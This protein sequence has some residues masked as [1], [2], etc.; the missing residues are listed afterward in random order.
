MYCEL[1]GKAG[2]YCANTVNPNASIEEFI[3]CGVNGEYAFELA[4]AEGT[5][6]NLEGFKDENPCTARTKGTN[7]VCGNAV[8]EDGEECETGFGC[9]T[10]RCKCKNGFYPSTSSDGTCISKNELITSLLFKIV[11]HSELLCRM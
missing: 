3:Y 5:Y 1:Y 4:C 11:E 7:P 8:V 2:Y 10:K 6:C 9:D